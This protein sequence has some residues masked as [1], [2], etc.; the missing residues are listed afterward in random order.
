[1]KIWAHRGCS[2]NYPENTLTSFSKAANLKNVVGIE[3]DTQ[4]TKDG[5]TVVIHDER[6]DRTTNGIGFVRDF[7]L[8]E[9]KQLAIYTGGDKIE[10][11]PTLKEV[12]EL[13]SGRLK[14]DDEF[15]L[16]IELKNSVY[17]YEEMEEKTINL[18]AKMGLTDSI[19]YSSFYTKS[20]AKVRKILPTANIAVLDTLV[21][22]CLY[23]SYGI[24]KDVGDAKQIALHPFWRGID[25]TPQ[26]LNGRIVRAWF[27]GH[28]F[29][30]KPTGNRLDFALLEA[31]GITDVMINEPEMY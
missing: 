25:L 10:R 17:Y 18:A 5:E 12:F 9:L 11:I 13:L 27:S 1:M 30:E 20:I 8:K 14:A 4:L 2:Q 6:V 21:S 29:P 16:N 26:E 19:V 28:L 15:K 24:A 3:L 22:N 31:H 23:K 7:T